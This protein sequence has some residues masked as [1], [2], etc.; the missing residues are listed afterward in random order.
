MGRE[1]PR[2]RSFRY[3]AY[4]LEDSFILREAC[5]LHCDSDQQAV[6]LASLL[7]DGYAVEVWEGDRLV[8][9]LPP[10]TFGSSSRP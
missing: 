2:V 10:K 6:E 8:R 1:P 7:S 5:P 3:R 9:R 4:L